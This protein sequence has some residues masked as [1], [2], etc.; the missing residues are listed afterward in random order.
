MG[1]K[2]GGSAP[3]PPDPALT[4]Q[5]Q[6]TSN[7]DTAREQATLNRINKYTPYGSLVNE[8][9]GSPLVPFRQTVSLNR[10]EQANLDKERSLTNTLLT[11]GQK[12]LGRIDQTLATPPPEADLAARQRVEEAIMSRIQPQ[13]DRDREALRTQL[14][15][16][17]FDQNSEGY[18]RGFDEFNRAQ[19]DARMQ[20]VLAGG[21]EQSRLFGLESTARMQP[22]QD[23]AALMGTSG[24]ITNPQ[25]GQNPQTPISPTNVAGPI[26]AAYQGQL[27][28]FNANQQNRSSTLGGLFGLGGSLGAAAITGGLFG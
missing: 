12:Q 25:F 6:T 21:R 3:Q 2:S 27:N 16:S 20:A 15:N 1:K 13:A 14:I 26:N 22:L 10:D 4:A 17:G 5:L 23:L 24:G 11:T 18:R 9:T 7:K 19:N 8:Y 28:A